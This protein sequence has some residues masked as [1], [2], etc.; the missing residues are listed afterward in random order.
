MAAAWLGT[1]TA[2]L[3]QMCETARETQVATKTLLRGVVVVR[4]DAL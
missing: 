3:R 1:E 2:E 4:M